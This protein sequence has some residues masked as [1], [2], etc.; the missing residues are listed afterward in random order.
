M[1]DLQLSSIMPFDLASLPPIWQTTIL[2]GPALR[3]PPGVQPN[4]V[5]P[6]NQNS[7]GY[8]LLIICFTVSTMMT[9]VRLY[10]K[11]ASSKK[12]GIEDCK[13]SEE[14]AG[15]KL[16]STR[17]PLGSFGCI[18]RFSLYLLR[19][20]RTTRSLRSQWR[21]EQHSSRFVLQRAHQPYSHLL[22]P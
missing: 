21:L 16:T 3:P 1:S 14:S 19:D 18:R 15:S 22:S 6:P 11:F 13:S 20:R 12:L 10:A 4:F 9:G 7:L 8:A 5:N 2:E 17:P